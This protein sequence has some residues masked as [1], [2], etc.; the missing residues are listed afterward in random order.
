MEL[1]SELLELPSFWGGAG[2]PSLERSADGEFIGPFATI[3]ASLVA[4]CRKTKLQVYLRVVDALEDMG[5]SEEYSRALV[6][7]A[8]LQVIG[9]GARVT[10]LV[11]ELSTEDILIAAH[12]VKV[13]RVVEVPRKSKSKGD[14]NL[15]QLVFLETRELSDYTTTPRRHERGII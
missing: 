12:L 5:C 6:S 9:V 4:L 8:V 13:E 11:G 3:T 10:A 14:P 15:E 7:N 1:L 2:F